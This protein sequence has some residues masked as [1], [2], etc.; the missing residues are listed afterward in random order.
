MFEKFS[1]QRLVRGKEREGEWKR[2]E[3]EEA[4][5]W[6]TLARKFQPLICSGII[7]FKKITKHGLFVTLKR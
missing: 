7:A 3:S 6:L 1:R 5:I 4:G 2:G